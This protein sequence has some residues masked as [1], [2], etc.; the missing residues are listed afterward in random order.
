MTSVATDGPPAMVARYRGFISYLK[1]NV[2]GV[3]AIHC[4]IHRH[5]VAKNLRLIP[6]DSPSSSFNVVVLALACAPD[7][8]SHIASSQLMRKLCT[9]RITSTLTY[10][11]IG[12]TVFSTMAYEKK[13]SRAIMVA[14]PSGS[15]GTSVSHGR[16]L[17]KYCPTSV[18][19][20]PHATMQKRHIDNRKNTIWKRRKS[21]YQKFNGN[22]TILCY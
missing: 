9:N 17:W 20:M 12:T 22:T 14:P 3:L 4:V 11:D 6:N 21:L 13:T 16:Y 1:Q 15:C 2:S 18:S 7:T 5:L 8:A 10:N 19:Q